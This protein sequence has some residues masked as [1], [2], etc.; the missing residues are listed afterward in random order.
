MG[1]V[2]KAELD[3]LDNFA[4]F[5][6]DQIPELTADLNELKNQMDTITSSAWKDKGGEGFK[7]SFSSFIT[8]AL[9]M[10]EELLK[11]STFVKTCSTD[12]ASAISTAV[13]SMK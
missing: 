13:N 6:G 1:D 7:T 5:L 2:I 3:S 9:K 4:I 12:Y 11:H 8:D 10:N